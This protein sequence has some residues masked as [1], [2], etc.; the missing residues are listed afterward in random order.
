MEDWRVEIRFLVRRKGFF[1]P[2]RSDGSMVY[3]ASFIMGSNMTWQWCNADCSPQ[4]VP[5]LKRVE[6]AVALLVEAMC[7]KTEGRGFQTRR[8]RWIVSIYLIF[9]GALGP[10]PLTE[11]STR[12]RKIMFLGRKVQG[13]QPYHHLWPDCLYNVGSSTSHNPIGLHG[14]L[15]GWLYFME[16]E[17]ASCEV[18]T[19]L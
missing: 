10:Q 15:R 4:F 14:L 18:R 9:P 11:M 6:H 7:Y 19:G 16:T 17:C 1:S 3:L 13:W 8:G 2:K 12:S 5:R